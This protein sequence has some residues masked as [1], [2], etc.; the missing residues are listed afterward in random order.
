MG[1]KKLEEAGLALRRQMFGKSGAEDA[2]NNAT[3]F[4][5]YFEE[6]VITEFCFGDVWNRKPLDHKMRSMLTVAILAA[7]GKSP[8]LRYHVQGAM[9]NG[10]SKE[11]LREV[12]L[13]V[14]LYAGIP[15]GAEGF[16]IASA[17]LKEM[18]L[19]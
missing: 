14:T 8:Q 11:E 19:E 13:Q 6:T 5:R 16:N 2:V 3:D 12:L 4:K 18:G 15:C 17:V 9:K 10:V 7:L 1:D